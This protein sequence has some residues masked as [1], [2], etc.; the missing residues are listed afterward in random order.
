MHGLRDRV[1]VRTEAQGPTVVS[2]ATQLGQQFRE[3]RKVDRLNHV[4]VESSFRGAAAILLLTPPG[5]SHQR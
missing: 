2:V 5:Q 4:G 1:R 3:S